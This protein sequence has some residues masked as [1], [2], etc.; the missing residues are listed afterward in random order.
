MKDHIF[1]LGI[2]EELQIVDP[3][4]RELRSHIQQILTDRKMILKERIK[5]ELHQSVVELDTEVCAM[6]ARPENKLSIFAA[7]WPDWRREMGS[8]SLPQAR[9]PSLIGWTS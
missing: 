5:P 6:P 9:I 4:T 3:E 1:T 7:N 2:E 8:R